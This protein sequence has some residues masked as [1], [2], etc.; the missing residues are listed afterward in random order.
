MSSKKTMTFPVGER[1]HVI[2]LEA[3]RQTLVLTKGCRIEAAHLL[4]IHQRTIGRKLLDMDPKDIARL[5]AELGK[6]AAHG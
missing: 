6:V 1:L 5:D 4:G 2:E 3:I